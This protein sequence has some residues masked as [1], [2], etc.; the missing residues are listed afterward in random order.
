MKAHPPLAALAV[1]TLALGLGLTN[2][3]ADARQAPA[4]PLPG[5]GPTYR[6]YADTVASG[7]RPGVQGGPLRTNVPTRSRL[8]WPGTRVG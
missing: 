5:T 2:V 1:A 4:N 8:L 6:I 3:A 7:E